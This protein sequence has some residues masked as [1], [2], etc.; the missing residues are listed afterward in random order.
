VI[1]EFPGGITET[2]VNL[3]GDSLLNLQRVGHSVLDKRQ[4]DLEKFMQVWILYA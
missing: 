4:T 1:P 2:T 3:K